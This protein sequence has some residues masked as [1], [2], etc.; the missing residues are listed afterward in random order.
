MVKQQL[1][2]CFIIIV[3]LAVY[4]GAATVGSSAWWFLYYEDGPKMSYWQLTHHMQ[5][6]TNPQLFEG[7]MCDIFKDLHPMTMAL[8]VLVTI[9]MLNALNR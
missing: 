4:V 9:E 6:S 2:D 3:I 1:A 8:S 5:C 7:M